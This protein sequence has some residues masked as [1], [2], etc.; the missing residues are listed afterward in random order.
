MFLWYLH[1][2]D[3]FISCELVYICEAVMHIIFLFLFWNIR[4]ISLK[5]YESN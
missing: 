4:N 1:F 2:L 5:A 3:A